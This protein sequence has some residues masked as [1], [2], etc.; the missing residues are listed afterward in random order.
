MK[1]YRFKR[2]VLLVTALVGSISAVA[3][4]FT[5]GG[6]RYDI[7][8]EVGFV[9]EV[10]AGE[11]KYQGTVTI[12]ATVT[13]DSKTYKVKAIGGGAFYE[14]TDLVTVEIG[15]NVE[16]IG[17]YAFWECTNL[18]NINWSNNIR[19]YGDAVFYECS[20]L[21]HAELSS[22]LESMGG[23]VFAGCINLTSVT[24]N[25]GCAI[26]GANAFANCVKLQSVSI[27]NSVTTL[28]NNAFSNC[29][30]L[31]LAYVGN[32]VRMIDIYTFSGCSSLE[33]VR[34]GPNVTEICM[35]A[36][37]SCPALKSFTCYTI[38]PPSLDETAFDAYTT[39]VYVPVDA[40]DAYKQDEVWSNFGNNIQS[41]PS[42][43]YLTIK[44]STGGV[45]KARLSVGETYNFYVQPADG[46]NLKSISFNGTDVTKQLVENTYVTPAITEDSELVVVFDSDSGQSKKGDLN[47]D[48]KVD[49][50]DHVELSKI[51]MNENY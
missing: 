43:V 7:I 15:S 26:V 3:E 11:T 31:K 34:I 41:F 48:G 35:F 51:I 5:K 19:S 40:V 17:T 47:N 10:V 20:S 28:G 1:C 46:V 49:V 14:C 45:V 13:H 9:V 32:G 2:L 37:F 42:Y 44:Q 6:V 23:N 36:F 4:S 25:D 29:T 22:K 33:T 27:P 18:K 16:S 21:E 30:A 8:D 24:I 38:A 39:A 50:A 12:P